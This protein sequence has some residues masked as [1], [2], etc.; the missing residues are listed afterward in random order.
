[1]MGFVDGTSLKMLEKASERLG[2]NNSSGHNGI[3]FNQK[4]KKWVAQITFKKK[5]HY[6]GSYVNIEDAVEA[7]KAGE[8]RFFGQFLDDWKKEAYEKERSL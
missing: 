4:N 7:R 3:Y 5:T 2:S 1:M 8:E 6:L